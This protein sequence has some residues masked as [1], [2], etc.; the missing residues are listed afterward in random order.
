MIDGLEFAG[1]DKELRGSLAPFDLTRLQDCLFDAGSTIDYRLR[2]GRDQQGRPALRLEITGLLHLQCQRCLGLLEYPLRM[3]NTLL[4]VRENEALPADADEPD[5]PD[6]IV[7]GTEM[8]VR[9]MIEDEILLGLPLSPRH[10][11]GACSARSETAR[12]GGAVSP[13]AALAVL[14]K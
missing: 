12:G 4:L 1:A 2:G 8:D 14:K 6:C 5:A 13:L 9:A 3:V 7:A 11:D 10:P